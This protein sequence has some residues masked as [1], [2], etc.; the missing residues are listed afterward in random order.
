ME[1]GRQGRLPGGANLDRERRARLRVR[2][3]RQVGEVNAAATTRASGEARRAAARSAAARRASARRP[4]AGDSRR[5]RAGDSR[6]PRAGDSRRPSFR[7][8]PG[9]LVLLV[10]F[11]SAIAL[12]VGPLRAY[13]AE[14]DRYHEAAAALDAARSEHAALR[15]QADRLTTKSYIAQQARKDSLLVPPGT[16]AFVIKGLPEED[17]PG[18]VELSGAAPTMESITVLERIEDLW[19]TLF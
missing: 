6:R 19:R 10:L 18:T 4:R 16:Q 3:I 12:Y 15:T 17:D 13:F 9:R 11:L 7:V 5:P 8:R 2:V 14:Q 1:Q